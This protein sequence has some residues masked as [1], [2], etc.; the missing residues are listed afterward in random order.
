MKT[1]L[2]QA[3]NGEEVA[4]EERLPTSVSAKLVRNR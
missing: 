4:V 1:Q 2:G 3:E